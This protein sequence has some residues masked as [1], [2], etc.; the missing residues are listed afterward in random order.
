[1]ILPIATYII[2][3]FPC[4]IFTWLSGCSVRV[5]Q[6]V[7]HEIV[8]AEMWA[9][10]LPSR[11]SHTVGDRS[12]TMPLGRHGHPISEHWLKYSLQWL[13]VSEHFTCVARLWVFFQ[14]SLASWKFLMGKP[15]VRQI[16]TL[17]LWLLSLLLQYAAAW[18]FPGGRCQRSRLGTHSQQSQ[19]W[20]QCLSSTSVNPLPDKKFGQQRFHGAHWKFDKVDELIRMSRSW[21]DL[22]RV[23]WPFSR[24]QI[25]ILQT[26]LLTSLLLPSHLQLQRGE[27]Q[28]EI[29]PRSCGESVSGF[30][31]F[32]NFK[33][34]LPM[35]MCKFCSTKHGLQPFRMWADKRNQR[36]FGCRTI[37]ICTVYDL[38]YKYSLYSCVFCI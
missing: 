35:S 29:S 34:R 4:H 12:H 37:L 10:C 6:R 18:T 38:I 33:V 5:T 9:T 23:R 36:L 16:L 8:A 22:G 27:L 7:W 13:P 14:H 15:H 19:Q 28:Q 21:G 25:N 20:I 26:H 24:F 30:V 2:Y 31:L 3:M 1:M 11:T 17:W 32:Y